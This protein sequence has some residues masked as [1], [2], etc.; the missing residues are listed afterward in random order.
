MCKT[1]DSRLIAIFN[2]KIQVVVFEVQ[3]RF[4]AYCCCN[5]VTR[6]HQYVRTR[7]NVSVASLGLVRGKFYLD[8]VVAHYGLILIIIAG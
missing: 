4:I 7:T 8:F 1:I 3:N 6:G 5:V 2:A